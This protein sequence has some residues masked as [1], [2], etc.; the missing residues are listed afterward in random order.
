MPTDTTNRSVSYY[1]GSYL[2]DTIPRAHIRINVDVIRYLRK[3]WSV[4]I[5]IHHPNIDNNW[6]TF[7][8]TIKGCNLWG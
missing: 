8:H 5:C 2:Y 3:G 1:V 7:L 4:I 6:L